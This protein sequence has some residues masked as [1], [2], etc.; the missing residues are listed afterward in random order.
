VL[1]GTT[2]YRIESFPDMAPK[3][4]S[5]LKL[6]WYI[7]KVI[8]LYL[9]HLKYIMPNRNTTVTQDEPPLII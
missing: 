4:V 9:G 5:R 8:L 6:R 7:T 2:V 3:M 1:V